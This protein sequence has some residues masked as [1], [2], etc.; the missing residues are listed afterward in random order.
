MVAGT[1]PWI[2]MILTPKPAAAHVSLVPL[3][4]LAEQLA[5]EPAVA[6]VQIVANLLVFAA[7]GFFAPIRFAALAGVVRL[8]MLG[9]AASGLVEMLQ[10]VL[11]L[12]RVSSVDDVLLNAVGATVAGLTS[13]HWWR[14]GSSL[15]AQASP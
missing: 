13:R 2:W 12:G 3:R 7:L 4:D 5:G 11:D 6:A 10:F 14:G 9:A 8:F 1:L 15:G